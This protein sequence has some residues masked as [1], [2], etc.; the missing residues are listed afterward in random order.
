[1]PRFELAPGEQDAFAV[2]AT[3]TRPRLVEWRLEADVSSQGKSS[4]LRIDD[5]GRPFRTAGT[6]GVPLV[7][8][9]GGGWRPYEP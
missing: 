4:L 5:G 3:T 8:W 6:A 2:H 9:R 7:E 1:V